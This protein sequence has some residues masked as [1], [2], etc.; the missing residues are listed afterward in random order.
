MA[1]FLAHGLLLVLALG[2]F[3]LGAALYFSGSAVTT[4]QWV[5]IACVGTFSFLSACF[6]SSTGA[7]A[8]VLMFFR[9]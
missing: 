3:A 7:V 8:S 9:P 5:L 4:W 2:A 6:E 1:S